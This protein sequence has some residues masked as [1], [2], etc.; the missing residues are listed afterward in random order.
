MPVACCLAMGEAQKMRAVLRSGND[1][2]KNSAAQY[3]YDIRKLYIRV[4]KIPPCRSNP[5]AT[6]SLFEFVQVVLGTE[7]RRVY[8]VN[9]L[10]N[11]GSKH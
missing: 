11:T 9:R 1:I 6:V 4:C 7:P 3:T 2:S 10:R 8:L 5:L